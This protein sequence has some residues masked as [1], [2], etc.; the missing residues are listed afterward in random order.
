MLSKVKKLLSKAK[1]LTNK[2]HGFKNRQHTK[3]GR[4]SKKTNVV[5]NRKKI[6]GRMLYRQSRIATEVIN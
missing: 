2:P 5:K 4:W 3:Q 6:N 1:N